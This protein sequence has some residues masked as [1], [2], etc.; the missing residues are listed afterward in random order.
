M[1]YIKTTPWTQ[2]GRSIAIEKAVAGIYE[3]YFAKGPRWVAK[4]LP[5]RSEMPQYGDR[6]SAE[7][8]EVLLGDY[9]V[10]AFNEDYAALTIR[11]FCDSI[12]TK[13]T[14][15]QSVYA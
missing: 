3:M 5:Q 6:V 15:T 1:V 9:G 2:M 11:A 14:F 13:Q 7:A 8:R 10:E 12:S 4:H